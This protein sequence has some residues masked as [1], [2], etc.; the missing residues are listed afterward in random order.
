M[1]F[2]WFFL[3][4]FSF[5][6]SGESECSGSFLNKAQNAV[7]NLFHGS[8]Q[9]AKELKPS[10]RVKKTLAQ[11]AAKPAEST[12]P[13]TPFEFTETGIRKVEKPAEE[14][15]PVQEAKP[16]E[17][18]Q[19]KPV[20]KPVEPEQAKP[21]EKPVEPEQA[22]PAEKPVEPEQ[23]KPV[24][25]TIT[26]TASRKN[27]SH[28]F[29]ASKEVVSPQDIS[30]L[31]KE[32]LAKIP[33][34]SLTPEHIKQMTP[35]QISG[36]SIKSLKD[37]KINTF[38]N[39]DQLNAVPI[40]VLQKIQ[41]RLSPEKINLL[42]NKSV[43]NVV[44][45]LSSQIAVLDY[46]GI[47]QVGLNNLG[48]KQ[49]PAVNQKI[50]QALTAEDLNSLSSKHIQAVQKQ[51]LPEQMAG[52]NIEAL[53][54]LTIS[55]LTAEQVGRLSDLFVDVMDKEPSDPDVWSAQKVFV[56]ILSM[57]KLRPQQMTD[58][59]LEY[60]YYQR[61]E[62]INKLTP[63][64]IRVVQEKL[65][66][67]QVEGLPKRLILTLD[68]KE[69]M[70]EQLQAVKPKFLPLIQEDLPANKMSH[71]TEV[72]TR[73]LN[74]KKLTLAQVQGIAPWQ[75]KIFL[76]K[77]LFRR[78]RL[79]PILVRALEPKQLTALLSDP[80]IK[81]SRLALR[82]LRRHLSPD[83]LKELPEDHKKLLRFKELSLRQMGLESSAGI[84]KIVTSRNL[85]R[86]L[87]KYPERV[88]YLDLKTHWLP[89]EELL[90]LQKHLTGQ[91]ISRLGSRVWELDFSRLSELQIIS[92]RKDQLNYFN[93]KDGEF[94]A[95]KQR[96]LRQIQSLLEPEKVAML[97][98]VR[99]K[100]LY[101]HPK[102]YYIPSLQML[103]FKKLST[104][105]VRTLKPAQL[106]ELSD[107]MLRVIRDKLLPEQILLIEDW[108][109]AQ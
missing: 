65:S 85:L 48:L 101:L 107:K 71:L 45:L 2:L 51:L 27:I 82:H 74:M 87:A 28:F 92:L 83:Q 57:K 104:L 93:T 33:V 15:K 62:D 109:P 47:K 76:T 18:E 36:L 53:K 97:D 1:K 61:P 22:K 66:D 24:E 20:E 68:V 25:Q 103:N 63:E 73:V 108:T 58:L 102:E 10:D 30:L 100:N 17:P 26:S 80:E 9:K 46:E 7:K 55:D 14:A 39:K 72:Q 96:K 88:G 59:T 75:L 23:A 67:E 8:S 49:I 94:A 86:F 21:V 5:F 54:K 84:D 60:L 79:S 70:P 91:Q 81:L 95:V 89:K 41:S 13:A 64:K 44:E 50:L 34:K 106:R 35:Q 16:V 6:S 52:L 19:A 32:E 90:R 77:G 56:Q 3:L 98:A 78:H 29:R 11:A 40:P 43:L 69:L 105:Q 38:L 37:S 99:P 31:T 4:T 42:T 12:R